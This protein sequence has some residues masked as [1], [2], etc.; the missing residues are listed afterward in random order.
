MSNNPPKSK[1]AAILLCFFVGCFGI[2]RFYLGYTL[3]GLIQLF[4]CGGFGIWALIDFVMLV[5]DEIPDSQGNKL[6]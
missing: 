1:A 6:I 4:T 3:F 5:V 2:H